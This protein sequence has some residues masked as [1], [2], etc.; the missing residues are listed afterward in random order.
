VTEARPGILIVDDRPE[1]R[2]ALAAVLQDLTEDVV[3]AVSGAA[4]LRWLLKRDFAVIL[5][6]VNMP[7]CDGFETAALIRQRRSSRST[8]II[9]V[10]AQGDDARAARGYSLGAVDY[11]VAPVDPHALRTK[12]SVF[13]DLHEKTEEV[14]RQAASLRRHAE[15][16]RRLAEAATEIHR[17]TS[18][19]DLVEIVADTAAS[20]LGAAQVAVELDP[21]ILSDSARPLRGAARG[22]FWRPERTGLAAIARGALQHVEARPI[23]FSRRELDEHPLWGRPEPSPDFVPLQGWLAAPLSKSDGRLLGWIQLSEKADEEFSA[24]DEAVLVQLAQMTAIAAENTQVAEA[25]EANRLKDQFLA[26]LSHELRTPLQSILTWSQLLREDAPCAS[27]LRRGLDVIDRNARAQTRLIE[28]LLDV[29]RIISGKLSLEKH[30]LRLGEFVTAAV[31]D[32]RPA[33]REK[34]IE[35]LLERRGDP[36]LTGDPHRLRQVVGNLLSNAIKFTPEAGRVTVSIGVSGGEAEVAVCD[37]GKGIA[38]EFLPHLFERFRQADSGTTRAQGGLGIGLAIA[39]H[40]AELHGG[41]V[42]AESQGEGR[43]ATFTARFPLA[44]QL[45]FRPPRAVA[46]PAPGTDLQGMR[47]LL[48]EDEADTRDGLARVLTKLGAVVE[49]VASAREALAA[50]DRG[51]PQILVSDL[52]MPEEDGFSLIRRVRARSEGAGGRIPAAALSAYVRPEERARA[53]LAGFD[54]HLPKPI[55]PAELASALR[56]LVAQGDA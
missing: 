1:Q 50:L 24:E 38:A 48:V 18:L 42:C 33:A 6:D 19:D 31:E 54:C 3:E 17:A 7:D 52:A 32:A 12:V 10:T 27:E 40:L 39:R 16:L 30:A 41:S 15:Q 25:R 20:I 5:L 35:I 55:E 37:T 36:W 49:P 11:I 28:D 4:A 47:I 21:A 46:S 9:F 56:D 45:G 26:T 34:Q 14:R 22:V 29:S 51:V 44:P 23:R 2:L 43:G 8:P 13:L 53:I